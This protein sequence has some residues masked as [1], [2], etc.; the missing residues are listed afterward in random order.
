[1]IR[2]A[3]GMIISITTQII[4]CVL[5]VILVY[6]AAVKGFEFGVSVFS[7]TAVSEAPGQDMIVIV[8]EGASALDVGKLLETKGL[9][10][11]EKV[12]FVQAILYKAHFYAGTYTLNTSMTSDQ[13][14]EILI[15]KPKTSEE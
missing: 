2:K 3:A 5:V 13:I 15:E 10:K 11:D 12:F 7:P 4:I 1:M 9:I 14:L 6:H 8:E